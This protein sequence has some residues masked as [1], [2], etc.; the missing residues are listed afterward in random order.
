MQTYGSWIMDEEK[1]G[2]FFPGR[3]LAWNRREDILM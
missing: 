3:K 2:E 1:N